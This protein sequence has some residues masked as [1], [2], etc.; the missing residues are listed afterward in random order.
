MKHLPLIIGYVVVIVSVIAGDWAI[1][2]HLMKKSPANHPVYTS[3]NAPAFTPPRSRADDWREYHTA[4]EQAMHD[5][6][7]LAAEYQALRAEIDKTQDDLNAAM[8]K[9]DPTIA[10]V[11]A[12]VALLR[13]HSLPPRHDLN[14]SKCEHR[15]KMKFPSFIFAAFMAGMIV[16]VAAP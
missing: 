2:T 10:P 6:P 15:C 9:A 1:R 3:S 5:N 14:Y 4:R 8:I 7:E 12:K 13:K 16:A 11:L